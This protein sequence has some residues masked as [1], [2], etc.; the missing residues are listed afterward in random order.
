VVIDKCIGS[1][2]S[3]R[4]LAGGQ[5]MVGVMV[6]SFGRNVYIIMHKYG[7]SEKRK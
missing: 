6:G 4:F 1:V 5:V 3:Y 7:E 2:Y